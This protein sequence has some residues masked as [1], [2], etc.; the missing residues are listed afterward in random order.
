MQ[1]SSI[2]GACQ[3]A[4][5]LLKHIAEMSY[6]PRD[7]TAR[8]LKEYLR[9]DNWAALTHY[10]EAADLGVRAAQ[11]N[12]AY[13]LE[14]MLPSEC[15]KYEENY[16]LQGSGGGSVEEDGMTDAKSKTD[17]TGETTHQSQIAVSYSSDSSSS[18]ITRRTCATAEECCR[19][20]LTKLA[21][22][23]WMQLA[24]AGEP[25]AMRKVADAL[26]DTQLQPY[27][28]AMAAPE[29]QRQQLQS[30]ETQAQSEIDAPSSQKNQQQQ[31]QQQLHQQ[32]QAAV[33]YALAGEQG[34]SE[35]L[36]RLG[37]MLYYGE[38]GE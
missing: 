21:T 25:R 15:E 18:S 37:W 10:E 28:M 8:A 35:S 36:L 27:M 16:Y 23:R 4:L 1:Q 32:R 3:A 29:P 19:Q 31:Q 7:L 6:R 24:Q 11:E 26:L 30:S 38:G 14:K 20:Y 13:L 34:D 9:G 5:P 2:A 12:A 33:L 17:S 22:R